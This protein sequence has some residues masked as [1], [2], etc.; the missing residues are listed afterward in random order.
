MIILALSSRLRHGARSRHPGSI[1]NRP[2]PTKRFLKQLFDF[3]VRPANGIDFAA[4]CILLVGFAFVCHSLGAGAALFVKAAPVF[5]TIIFAALFICAGT[6][7][8]SRD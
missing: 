5:A 7:W 8:L 1:W 4:R 3:S 2:A 6:N